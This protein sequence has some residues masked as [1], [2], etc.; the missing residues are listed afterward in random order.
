MDRCNLYFRKVT[1]YRLRSRFHYPLRMRLALT[2]TPSE[3]FVWSSSSFVRPLGVSGTAWN[4]RTDGRARTGCSKMFD[5]FE[6]Q[7]LGFSRRSNWIHKVAC[8]WAFCDRCATYIVFKFSTING[9]FESINSQNVLYLDGNCISTAWLM[10]I[11]DKID[12]CQRLEGRQ[13][14]FWWSFNI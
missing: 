12:G 2:R 3:S 9:H 1:R 5:R 14:C 11:I 7:S 6:I 8:K 13:F 4:G 10:M